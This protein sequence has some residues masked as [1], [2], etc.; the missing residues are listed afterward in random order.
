MILIILLKI[1]IIIFTNN[2]INFFKLDLPLIYM[3]Y[4]HVVF[5]EFILCRNLSKIRN[6]LYPISLNNIDLVLYIKI[7]VLKHFNFIIFCLS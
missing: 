6:A 1:I 7:F 3:I 4:I 2:D 5:L